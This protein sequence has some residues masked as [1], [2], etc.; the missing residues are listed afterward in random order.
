MDSFLAS[1]SFPASSSR[2]AIAI[3]LSVVM[4]TTLGV[5]S[6]AAASSPVVIPVNLNQPGVGNFVGTFSLQNFAVVNNQLVAIGTL[7]GTVTNAAG[8]VLGSVVQ[9]LTIPVSV[10]GTCQ[11]LHLTLGPLDLDLLGL[12][13]HLD[14]I[15]LDITAQSGPGN[16]LGNL[17]CA[18]ANLLNNGGALSQLANV[19]NQILGQL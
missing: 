18:V 11:I 5:G 17:L 2:K 15:V 4:L 13:V 14:R 10:T 6:L 1:R 12:M 8:I 7:A 9:T 3:V 19:L 16:L